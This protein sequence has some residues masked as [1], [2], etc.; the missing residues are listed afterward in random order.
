MLVPHGHCSL[1]V[2]GGGGAEGNKLAFPLHG[3]KEGEKS[4]KYIRERK[5]NIITEK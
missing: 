4:C 3:K 2:V 1:P 5:W